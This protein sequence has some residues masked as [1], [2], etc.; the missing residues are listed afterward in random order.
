MTTS[1][2][3]PVDMAMLMLSIPRNMHQRR[4]GRRRAHA[5]YSHTS[6]WFSFVLFT[7]AHWKVVRNP[8]PNP[9]SDTLPIHLLK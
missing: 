4:A 7:P 3:T 5:K 9:Y 1:G 2:D 6:L 8:N